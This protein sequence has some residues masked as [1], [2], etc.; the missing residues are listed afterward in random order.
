MRRN[1]Q[2][3]KVPE[4]LEDLALIDAKAITA[5]VCISAS[6]WNALVSRGDAP[7]P[8]FRGPR[9]TRW[10]L[11]EVREWIAKLSR[12]G[13]PPGRAPAESGSPINQATAKP[14]PGWRVSSAR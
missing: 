2:T 13:L 10:R 6:Q 8:V 14:A 1:Q 9:C 5:A 7:Q 11:A 4:A 12:D 3:S